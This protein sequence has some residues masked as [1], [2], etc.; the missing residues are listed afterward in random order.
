MQS[1]PMLRSKGRRLITQWVQRQVDYLMRDWK[2]PSPTESP[3]LFEI[4][5]EPIDECLTALG[6]VPLLIQAARSLGVPG[7][8][9]QHVGLKQ[10]QRGLDEA[11]YV[12]S[13]VILNALGG[14]CLE[15]FERLRE[16]PGLAEMAGYEMPSPGAA[17]KFL[18][19]FHDEEKVEQA[20]GK[21]RLGQASYI[22]EE[23]AALQGLGRVNEEVVQELGRRC[24]NQ[25][26]ATIDLDSTVIESWKRE[27]KPTYEGGTGYQPMLALWAEMDVIVAEEF[28]DGNVPAIQEPLRVARRAFAALPDT[29]E[30]RYF[31]GDAACYQQELVSWLRNQEREGPRGFI[32]FAISAPMMP[33]LREE[34]VSIEEERWRAYQEDGEVIK[35]WAQSDYCPEQKQK[36]GWEPLRYIAVRIRKR[37]G[38]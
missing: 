5:A 29:V 27:A 33:A 14:D 32:G 9:K 25:K 19:Q 21:L 26:M 20:Q 7:S 37:Q 12:E 8:V 30:E 23:S 17:R 15:D 16:D 13:F 18:Y 10:R 35:E 36:W 22:P 3:L 28:R 31:R 11:S 2:R 38:D 24:P 1:S 6:G 4:D 34:I